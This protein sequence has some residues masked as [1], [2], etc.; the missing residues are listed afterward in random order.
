M[1]LVRHEQVR[2][3]VQGLIRTML[4]SSS[5]AGDDE[6]G[7]G[8]GRMEVWLEEVGSVSME[9]EAREA[10]LCAGHALVQ[11]GVGLL[12]CQKCIH[13]SL[14]DYLIEKVKSVIITLH[15]SKCLVQ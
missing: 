11:R 1:C 4:F 8:F 12:I 5:L 10:L 13:P 9:E 3:D 2:R 14:K 15:L 7:V 6:G